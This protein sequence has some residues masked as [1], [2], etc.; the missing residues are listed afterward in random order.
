[1]TK[2]LRFVLFA[3]AA[4]VLIGALF[5]YR[6]HLGHSRDAV[7][8]SFPIAGIQE[9][10]TQVPAASYLMAHPSALKAAE[11]ACVNGSGSN[12]VRLCD[13]VHSAEAGLMAAKYRN[14]AN[15]APPPH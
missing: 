13:R 1:M 12:I 3:L 14:G 4:I 7:A 2:S 6:D 5:F 11:K 15:A 9:H 10:A 8:P